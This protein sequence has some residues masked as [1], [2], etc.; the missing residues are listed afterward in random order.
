[1]STP[2]PQ[3]IEFSRDA[4]G[5]L[6][7]VDAEGVRHVNVH[8]A[9][10]FPLTEKD[11]WISIQ[12]QGAREIL[13]IEDPQSLPEPSRS[14]LLEALARRDFV[15][16]IQVIHRIVRLADG[17]EWHVTTDRGDTSFEVETDESIQP[18][19]HGRLV[20]MDRR[21]T[22]YLIPDIASLDRVSKRKLEHYY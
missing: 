9:K 2:Q 6:V 18:L 8:P 20:I 19:G 15:P 4:Q 12:S 5:R 1:M 7:L 13:C 11:H 3:N 17:H 14:L 22:R 10:L 21:N 16:V